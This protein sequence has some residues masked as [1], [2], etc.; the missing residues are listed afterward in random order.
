MASPQHT[1]YFAHPDQLASIDD[2]SNFDDGKGSTTPA[3]KPCQPISTTLALFQPLTHPEV[4]T[5]ARTLHS[6]LGTGYLNLNSLSLS[7]RQALMRIPPLQHIIFDLTIPA[8]PESAGLKIL[9]S[10]DTSEDEGVVRIEMTDVI[11]MVN[12][13]ATTTRMRVDSEGSGKN[14]KFEMVHDQSPDFLRVLEK[15]LYNCSTF[16]KDSEVVRAGMTG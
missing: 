9:W 4:L 3:G 12:T 15:Q 10:T 5:Q 1:R 7:W 8:L 14:L 6:R 2:T 11:L 13:I 16:R